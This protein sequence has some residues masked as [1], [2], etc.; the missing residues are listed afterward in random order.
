VPSVVLGVLPSLMA[1]GIHA[2][3]LR[4]LLRDFLEVSGAQVMPFCG[5]PAA[6]R[7]SVRREESCTVV[8]SQKSGGGKGVTW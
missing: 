8:L 3:E 4:I 5:A 1:A 2:E 6:H 7:L